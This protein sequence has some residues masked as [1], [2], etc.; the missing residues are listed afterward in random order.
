M[1]CTPGLYL[2]RQCVKPCGVKTCIEVCEAKTYQSNASAGNW[3]Q[4]KLMQNM[5]QTPTESNLLKKCPSGCQ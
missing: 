5:P 1:Y 2:V 3:A 4:G